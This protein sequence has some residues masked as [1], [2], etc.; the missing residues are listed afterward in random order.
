MFK[1]DLKTGNV[2][3]VN[4]AVFEYQNINVMNGVDTPSSKRGVGSYGLI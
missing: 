3:N 1:K 2:S 4:M